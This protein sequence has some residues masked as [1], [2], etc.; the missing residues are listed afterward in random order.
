MDAHACTSAGPAANAGP[1]TC[2]TF[3]LQR[4]ERPFAGRASRLVSPMPTAVVPLF[5]CVITNVT[6]AARSSLAQRPVGPLITKSPFASR[7]F[8][9][10]LTLGLMVG[11]PPWSVNPTRRGWQRFPSAASRRLRDRSGVDRD[12]DIPVVRVRAARLGDRRPGLH[13]RGAGLEG[14][15]RDVRDAGAPVERLA[16]SGPPEQVGLADAD[17]DV[18]VH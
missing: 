7:S 17:G 6:T 10:L 1:E 5:P 13:V 11:F 15:A 12:V 18:P 2:L 4:N 8:C 3:P 16:V 14:R 9:F